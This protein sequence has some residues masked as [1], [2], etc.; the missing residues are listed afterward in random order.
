MEF[1]EEPYD[2]SSYS[3]EEH[4]NEAPQG[5]RDKGLQIILVMI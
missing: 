4:D 1:G 5:A 3:D 2:E